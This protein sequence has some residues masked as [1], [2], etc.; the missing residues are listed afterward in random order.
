VKPDDDLAVEL[1]M[2]DDPNFT[3]ASATSERELALLLRGAAAS[4]VL[5]GGHVEVQPARIAP[6]GRAMTV[7]ILISGADGSVEVSGRKI[8]SGQH[9]LDPT[10]H[11][12]AGIRFLA[13]S[14]ADEKGPPPV[15]LGVRVLTPQKQ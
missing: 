11:R 1:F 5:P 12:L 6:T 15:V 14:G 3:G 13:R 9:H 2:S 8:W 10:R 7:R 4:V